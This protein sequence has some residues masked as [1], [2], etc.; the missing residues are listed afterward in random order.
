MEDR[1]VA[2]GKDLLV[3][4]LVFVNDSEEFMPAM[5]CEKGMMF[6]L[7]QVKMRPLLRIASWQIAGRN[8]MEG[9]EHRSHS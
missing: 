8:H 9:F 7:D 5:K 1:G 4:L 3:V 6:R 2:F